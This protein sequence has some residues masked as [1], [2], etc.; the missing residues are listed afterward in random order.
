MSSIVNGLFNFIINNS[1]VSSNNGL[2]FKLSGKGSMNSSNPN[3][4]YDRNGIGFQLYSNSDD[5]RDFAF[6]DTSNIYNNDYSTL[7]IGLRKNATLLNSITSNNIYKPLIINSNIS[8]TSNGVGIGTNNPLSALDV[9]GNMNVSGKIIMNNSEFSANSIIIPTATIPSNPV[10]GSTNYIYYQ[11]DQN[12]TNSITFSTSTFADLFIVGAGGN[13]GIGTNSGGGGAGEVIYYPNFLFIPGTYNINI[14]IASSNSILRISKI[15]YNNSDLIKAIGGGDGGYGSTLPTSGGSGGGGAINQS[16]IIAGTP[17]SINSYL[18]GGT[19]GNS[20]SGGNGGSAT[21]SGRFTTTITGSTLSVGLGG[22]GVSSSGGG[23]NAVN[24]GDGGNGNGGIGKQGII[25]IRIDTNTNKDILNIK[26]DNINFQNLIINCNLAVGGTIYRSDGSIFTGSGNSSSS[27]TINSKWNISEGTSNIYYNEGLVGIGLNNPQS[28]L[29]LSSVNANSDITLKFTDGST[30]INNNGLILKKDENQNGLFWNYQNADLLFGTSNLERMRITS[31]GRI[32]IGTS[33]PQALL[34]VRGNIVIAG[35][36]LKPDGSKLYASQLSNS[37]INPNNIYYNL[38]YLGIGTDNPTSALDVRNGNIILNQGKIGIGLT[39]PNADIHISSI[40]SNSS[41]SLRITDGTTGLSGGISLEKDSNQNAKL[42]NYQNADIILGTNNLERMRLTSSGRVGIGTT[43]PQAS[44]DVRGNLLLS[45]TLLKSNGTNYFNNQL[46]VSP[47]NSNNIY[48]NLGN[49]GIGT[50]NPKSLLDVTNG[51]ITINN[52]YLGIGTTNPQ[53][54]I[55]LSA[56]TNNTEVTLRLTDAT[57]GTSSTSGLILSKDTT[58]NAR[59]WN[60]QNTDL[61]FGT[62]NLERMRLTSSGRV[63]IGTTNP[64]ATMDIRGNLIVSGNLNKPDGSPFFSSQ[65]SNSS[66]NPNNVYYNLGNFGIGT[67][68]PKA[69]L[70]VT[71][72]N[73]IVNNGRIGIGTTNPQSHIHLSAP[74]NDTEVTLRLTDATSGSS[75]TSGLILSKDTNQN[76]RL[77]NYQNTDLLLGTNNLERMRLTSS[78]RVGIGTTNPQALLDVRGNLIVS[79]NLNK[80]DGSPFFSSQLLNSSIN[81]NNIYYNLGNIGIG[82]TNPRTGLDVTNGNIIVNNGRIG[83]GTTNPQSQIHLSALT[84]NTEVTLRLT[85]ATTGTSSTSGLILSK[86]TNQN[87]RLWNYQN[88][89]LLFGTNNLERMRISSN[90][91]IGIGTTNPLALLD[92]RGNLIVSG[93]LNKPDGSPFFSSQLSNSVINPNNIYYNIGNFGIGTTNPRA[94]LDVTNGNIIVNNGRMGIGTT[95]PQSQIHLSAS[96]NNTEVTL[97]LTD[98]TTGTSSTSGLILSK[99]TNQNG[100]LWNYQNA[101]LLFGTNNLERMRISSNGRIGIGTTNPLNILDVRGNISL[102]GRLLRPDGSIFFSSQFSNSP[103]VPNNIYYNQGFV[104]IGT[105]NPRAGLDITNGNV[106]VTGGSIGIGLTNPQS[107]IHLSAASTNTDVILRMTDGTTGTNL[108]SGLILQKD[109]NQNGLLWNYQN[110]HIIFGTNNLERMRITSNGRIG[111]GTTTPLYTLDVN[112]NINSTELLIKGTNISNIIDNKITTTSNILVNYNNLINKPILTNYLISTTASNTF[113]TITN[114]SNSFISQSNAAYFYATKTDLSTKQNNITVTAPIVKTGDNI[115]LNYDTNSFILNSNNQLAFAGNFSQWINNGNNIYYNLGNVGIGTTNPTAKLHIEHNSTSTSG[116]SAGL[117][118]YN[119]N[120]VVNNSSVI[121]TRIAGSSANKTGYS[122]E[123]ANNFGWSMYIQGND[124]VNKTLRFNNTPDMTGN[125]CFVIN[126]NNN[127][128]GIGTNN[129]TSLLHLNSSNQN[130][131]IGIRFT[132]ATT[133]YTTTDGLVLEKTSNNDGRF[134]NYENADIFFGTNN[135]ERL[136]IKNDGRIGVGI[137]PSSAYLLQIHNNLPASITTG[138]LLS[139]TNSSTTNASAIVKNNNHNLEIKTLGQNDII[140]GTSNIERIRIKN[141]GN[142][143]IGTVNPTSTLHIN[144]DLRVSGRILNNDG[145]EYTISID[146]P[147][148]INPNIF[149][150]NSSGQ[151]NISNFNITTS[152]STTNLNL[153]AS[154]TNINAL[155]INNNLYVGQKIGIQQSPSY[156]LDV[157]SFANTPYTFSGSSIGILQSSGATT[158]SSS[159]SIANI[160]IKANG[161]IWSTSS[162][163]ASSDSRIKTNINDIIDDNA[164]QKI[165]KIEPK[166][167]NYIDYISKGSCNVY[168][169]IAQQINE[170][171]PEAITIK[172]EYIPNIYDIGNIDSNRPNEIILKNINNSINVNDTVRVISKSNGINDYNITDIR[173]SNCIVIDNTINDSNCIVYGTKINDFYTL[174][175]TYIYTLNVCATQQLY[176]III[177]QQKQLENLQNIVDKMVDV[178]YNYNDSN[179]NSNINSIFNNNSNLIFNNNDSN[180]L[181][182][183]NNDSNITSNNDSNNITFNNDSNNITFNNSNLN[184]ISSNNLTSN[185]DSNNITFN[186][187]SNNI[188]FN[189]DSNNITF[190]NDSNI[191]SNNDNNLT[192]NNDSNLTFNNDSNITSNND[193]NNINL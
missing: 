174:D 139:D 83:I 157:A 12:I 111:I 108:T 19:N 101:A 179:L 8:I 95:N 75:S 69:G 119:P 116:D 105:T 14:G 122:L 154:N 185:N 99:D 96:T 36:L 155:N 67:T 156:P 68:N 89:D 59:L 97:R 190:N 130:T 10:L 181:I 77:W 152:G 151:L 166:T 188:T 11:F 110:N 149:Y 184:I 13:G 160:V 21:S 4:S 173:S 135:V 180:N 162:F 165:L 56:S 60:Y 141:N 186:N 7:R 81:P 164:L 3:N 72:G 53:S 127:N 57:S 48:Y 136:R 58:Q 109:S 66:I 104:G 43:N 41:I 24:F 25:I 125:D 153:S 5:Y 27:T 169:F 15:V 98:A 170:I 82:T 31:S 22:L 37:I 163:I 120:N 176:N 103:I 86:D 1:S 140:L 18:T 61:L 17:N 159:T 51:N 42:W 131:H 128:V 117:Y 50:T 191:T 76:A 187:D 146:K 28:L 114:A 143:G 46:F 33:N 54:H 150:Y 70:D 78:G 16:G 44:L 63:G 138:I 2:T 20:L 62:N 40:N 168:G 100:L 148:N 65:L 79:G 102:S 113:I 124:S 90:G 134:W 38:G 182:F 178:I 52:G 133:G 172:E 129:P 137:N 91:R 9:R 87:A 47:I 55:H 88:T 126:G 30:G 115:S 171:I 26:S 183:N 132:D 71:N 147:L 73:I 23:G 49:F 93:N 32:G 6:V 39:Q 74:T 29:H 142:I 80:P 92:I 161:A 35:N 85:D 123:V 175:K 189:N 167:Y 94:G 45:G 118:V 177:E 144:G 145:T 121:C 84:N 107:L 34:D 112:G 106:I 64:Q 192:S 158:T 193:S